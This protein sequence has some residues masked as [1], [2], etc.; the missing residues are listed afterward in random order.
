[1]R[2]AAQDRAGKPLGVACQIRAHDEAAH[3]VPEQEVGRLA[4][5]ARRHRLAQFVHVFYQDVLAAL[6]RQAPALP[7][8]GDALAVAYVVVRAHH[9]AVP[10]Q[11]P[12]EIVVAA[13]VLGHAVHQLHD[14]RRRRGASARPGALGGPNK[15]LDLGFPIA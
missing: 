9:V 5:V 1:M 14:A 12:R 13:D 7:R 10:H 8:V 15:T 6:Q 2:R 11:K 3:G 4:G